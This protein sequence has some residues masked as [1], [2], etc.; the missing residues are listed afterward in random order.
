MT[1]ELTPARLRRFAL[2]WS[3]ALPALVCSSCADG[4]KTVYPV[5]GQVVWNGKPIQHAFVALH[6]LGDA[7]PDAVHPVGRTDAEGRFTLSTYGAG[8]GAPSG[9]YAVTVEWRPLP[10]NLPEGGQGEAANRLPP[11]YAN[12][13]TSHLTVQIGM[14]PTELPTIRLEK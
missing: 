13:A 5:Q 10:K 2:A 7:G 3:F 14:G 6:P 8:D 9:E 11:R 12:P 1:L 4:R